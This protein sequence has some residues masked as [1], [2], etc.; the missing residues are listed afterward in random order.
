LVFLACEAYWIA[1]LWKKAPEPRELPEAMRAQ[2]YTLQKQVERDL[3]RIRAWRK[4]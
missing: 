3:A 4:N 2:I 1:M